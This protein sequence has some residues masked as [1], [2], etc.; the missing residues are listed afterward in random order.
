MEIA[1]SEPKKRIP[2]GKV[3]AVI[4]IELILAVGVFAG[5]FAAGWVAKDSPLAH[6]LGLYSPPP[7][8]QAVTPQA[9][10]SLFSPFWEAWDLLH[11]EYVDKGSLND[12]ELMRGAIRGMY[13]AVGD[14]H[15]GYMDPQEYKDATESLAGEYEGIGAWVDTGGEYLTIIS[16]IPGSPAEK[17]GL[18]NGDQVIAID[19]EDMSGVSPEVARRKV[20]GPAGSTVELTIRRPGVEEPFTVKITRARI[21]IHSVEGKML[22]NGLAYL[23]LITFGEKTASELRDALKSLLDQNPKGLILDL[24]NNGGGYLQTAVDVV[25]E[26]VPDGAVLYEEYGDGTRNT[27]KVSGKGIATKIPIVVLVNEGTASA[28]E[29]VA[30]AI[31]DHGRGKLVGVTTYG[32]GSVQ[33]WIPL[34]N[35]QGAVRITIARWLTPNGYSIDKKGLEPDFVVKMSEEDIQNN[36]DPQL[37]KAVE[38]LLGGG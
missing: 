33:N 17:A 26:F 16:P 6:L 24:R 23:Q 37:D 28:S 1:S 4:F 18:R 34:S 9:I 29:I 15:T 30:G 21:T 31:R 3:L 27:Y 22:D 13:E 7:E 38:I 10:Q 35:E 32:K 20:L 36:R 8:A 2:W 19:G 14:K 25:S 12:V 11:Q 5:G